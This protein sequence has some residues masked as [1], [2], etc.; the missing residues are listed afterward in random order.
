MVAILEVINKYVVYLR[1]STKEQDLGIKGQ[2]EKIDTFVKIKS[3]SVIKTFTE[4]ESGLN[5]N[6]PELKKAIKYAE[7]HNAILLVSSLDRLTRKEKK[8]Y[9][10]QE[11]K[12]KFQCCDS[13]DGNPI[14]MGFQA[15][16]ARMY[17]DALRANTKAALG[18]IKKAIKKD[19]KY[20]TKISGRFITRLGN[21][22]NIK[23]ASLLGAEKRKDNAREYAAEIMP[24]INEIKNIGKVITLKGIADALNARGIKTSNEKMWWATSVK[25]VMERSL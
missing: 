22:T 8:F 1:T 11:E 16:G 19:G 15:I 5:D 23:E 18:Q 3:G 2:K 21:T 10:L 4:K 9:E 25:N 6:R 17:V 14:A 20:K 13:P 24:I 12:V 7:I